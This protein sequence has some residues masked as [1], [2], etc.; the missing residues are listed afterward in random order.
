MKVHMR[1]SMFISLLCLLMLTSCGLFGSS[2]GESDSQSTDNSADT[3]GQ[4]VDA[5]G[6]IIPVRQPAEREGL[7]SSG[8][9]A[10]VK[11][12]PDPIFI[13]PPAGSNYGIGSTVSHVV[14]P[15]EW[16]YQVARCYGTS[17][18]DVRTAN[19]SIIN[20]DY[21]FPENIVTVPNVGL[22]GP[23]I[24]PNC[25]M[26]HVV[27]PGETFYGLARTYQTDP[28][29]LQKAN[30]GPLLAGDIIFVPAVSPQ[31]VAPPAL[32]QSLLFN[33]RGDLAVWRNFDGRVELYEDNSA[34][35]L[36]M[37]T[38]GNGRFILVKQTRDQGAS[39]E[40]ALID[41]TAKTET[42]IETNLTP[43]VD[44]G[45]KRFRTS[46]L[47]SPN[48]A[49]GAYLVREESTMRLSTF[50]TSNPG[51]LKQL[52]GIPHGVMDFDTPQLFA[53]G[54]D[55][56]VLMLDDTGIYE[57]PYALD[58]PEKQVVAIDKNDTSKPPFYEA[59]AW[60]PTSGH[61]LLM[62]LFSEGWQH[63]VL[64][65]NS[66]SVA[67]V[68]NSN[69]YV[70]N[71]DATWLRNGHVAAISPPFANEAGP[72]LTVYRPDST[73][74]TLTLVEVSK[75]VL[76]IAGHTAPQPGYTISAP[77][78]QPLVDIVDFTIV[79]AGV[80][81]SYWTA[82]VGSSEAGRLNRVPENGVRNNWTTD[83]SGLLMEHGG[84][85][86][87]WEVVFVPMQGTPRFSL[88][89]WFGLQISHFNWV[90]Q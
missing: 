38:H 2:S 28:I 83:G 9:Q 58:A 24:G 20:P 4:Q 67:L 33:L 90:T 52:A 70:I 16:L 1:D 61:L 69:G 86:Q 23:V 60:S 10:A 56:H 42:V 31:N 46:L 78:V 62:G 55:A 64:D 3:P 54:D 80:A 68:P 73:P 76:S 44:D 32:S 15:Y 51:D 66:G 37:A 74:T 12:L 87:P 72:I 84:N 30:P 85:D 26:Q 53:G 88:T 8:L 89:N 5:E 17:Y 13:S 47:V 18:Q 14:E 65:K 43:E 36:D 41:R 22:V 11:P 49:W 45:L 40:I 7:S 59:V 63:Y 6:N 57:Y 35:I 81:S 82:E 39:L 79:G 77:P 48:G 29:I 19:P 50:A 21:I 71:A 25:I 75:N 34:F 27:A